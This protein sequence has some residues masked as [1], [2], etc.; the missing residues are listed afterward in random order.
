MKN[1]D[2]ATINPTVVVK[3]VRIT[4]TPKKI[5]PKLPNT[6]RADSVRTYAPLLTF[7]SAKTS[8][9][10]AN[11]LPKSPRP[12]YKI[13][14]PIAVTIPATHV[15]AK[16][17]FL[18]LKPSCFKALIA[19]IQKATDANASSVLYPSINPVPKATELV[20]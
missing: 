12:I 6:P 5:P 3:H 17:S 10:T 16:N 20:A 13:L 8:A 14:N 15:L 19:I 1:S 7:G 2:V 18:S 11:L 9:G 4:I